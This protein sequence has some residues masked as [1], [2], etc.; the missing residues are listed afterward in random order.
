MIIPDPKMVAKMNKAI[1]LGGNLFSI[2][3]IFEYLKDGRMQ[4]H[5]EGDTWVITQ[6]HDWPRKR[7][8]NLLYTVGNIK[9]ASKL[10]E[11][12]TIWAKSIGADTITAIGGDGWWKYRLPNWKKVGTLY[13]KDI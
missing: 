11:K 12:I 3:D 7:S 4:S 2:E 6:I 5:A 10:E 13:S 8:V 1:A 9:E